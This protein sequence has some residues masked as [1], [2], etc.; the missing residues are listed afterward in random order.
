MM[1]KLKNW[2]GVWS[3]NGPK[4]AP[5]LGFNAM[6]RFEVL[7]LKGIS[8]ALTFAACITAF[9]VSAQEAALANGAPNMPTP[10]TV[11]QPYPP[12][13]AS[14]ALAGKPLLDAL[15]KGGFTL[16]LRHTETGAAIT[17]QCDVSNLSAKGI[18]MARELGAQMKQLRI[19]VG[20]VVSSP[21][22]RVQETARLLEMGEVELSSDL[23]QPSKVL[24]AADLYGA[25]MRQLA[26]PPRQG[27]NTIA[28]GHMHGGLPR[29]QTMDLEF[30]EIIV[31]R[32][33]GGVVKPLARVRAENWQSL[34][35]A[36]QG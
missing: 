27:T 20:R 6:A 17:E 7:S 29:H 35:A 2:C 9:P 11:R 15:R 22:C 13:D 4:A 31:F 5:V 23:A 16:Y 3:E 1:T 34:A 12:V 32:A 8:R 24:P 19:P 30:G 25:R 10:T 26:V 18:A 14:V 33:D 21:V 28:V 36:N